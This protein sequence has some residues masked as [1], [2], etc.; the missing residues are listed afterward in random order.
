V[1]VTALQWLR[2]LLAQRLRRGLAQ[3]VAVWEN[4]ATPYR[5]QRT[6]ALLLESVEVVV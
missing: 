2:D 5:V 6:K 4:K 1:L 3:R